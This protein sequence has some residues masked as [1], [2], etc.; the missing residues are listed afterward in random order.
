VCDTSLHHVELTIAV[1]GPLFLK[2]FKDAWNMRNKHREMFHQLSSTFPKD[3]IKRWTAMVDAW[4]VD[5][6]RPNPYEEPQCGM[7]V[8]IYV[9]ILIIVISY[10]YNRSR[11][12]APTHTRRCSGGSAWY[13]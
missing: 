5:H 8:V 11:C 12:S 6:G 3:T 4:K 1:I 7:L 2:R 13:C 9:D 10:S